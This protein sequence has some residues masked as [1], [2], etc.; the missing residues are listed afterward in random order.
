[1]VWLVKFQN[2][3]SEIEETSKIGQTYELCRARVDGLERYAEK[4]DRSLLD[5]ARELVIAIRNLDRATR[6]RGESYVVAQAV[7]TARAD[8]QR[9][10]KEFNDELAGATGELQAPAER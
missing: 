1:M 9:M 3:G 7:R 8:L 6:T 4:S 10:A 5:H 2:D